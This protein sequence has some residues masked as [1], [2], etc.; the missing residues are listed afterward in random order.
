MWYLVI[1]Q[2]ELLVES[3]GYLF[4]MYHQEKYIVPGNINALWHP[5]SFFMPVSLYVVAERWLER[6]YDM[7]GEGMC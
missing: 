4:Q 2:L 6:V 5:C 3:E 1:V 7:E